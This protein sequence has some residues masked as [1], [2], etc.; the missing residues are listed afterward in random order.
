MT[1]FQAAIVFAAQLMDS[2]NHG[3]PYDDQV[4]TDTVSAIVEATDNI[5]EVGEACLLRDS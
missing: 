1:L 2:T 5:Q 3:M 4:M